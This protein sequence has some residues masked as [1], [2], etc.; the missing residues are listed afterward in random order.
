VASVR[1]YTSRSWQ[2]V[3]GI[4]PLVNSTSLT[5]TVATVVV[6]AGRGAVVVGVA[7]VVEAGGGASEGRVEVAPER[8]IWPLESTE[9][10]AAAER[11]I[12]TN[13]AARRRVIV[14]IGHSMAGA[15]T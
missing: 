14:F 8:R 5:S 9:P 1:R 13:R 3:N 6:V 10:Q 11:V 4:R 2:A 7:V 15:G 12:T